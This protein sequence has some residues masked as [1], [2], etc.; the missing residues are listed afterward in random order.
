MVLTGPGETVIY[1]LIWAAPREINGPQPI[2]SNPR[3]EAAVLADE[4]RARRPGGLT[5]P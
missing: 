2:I 5:L 3:P 1:H 4:Q